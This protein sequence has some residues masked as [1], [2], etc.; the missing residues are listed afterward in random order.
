LLL[1]PQLCQAHFYSAKI[2]FITLK[3][4]INFSKCSVFASSALLHLFFTSISVVF[5]GQEAQKYFLLQG[6]GYPSYATGGNP[7][8]CLAQ[9]HSK[10]IKL[11]ALHSPHDPFITFGLDERFDLLL[12]WMS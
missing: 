1:S 2:R 5:C 9:G 8:K 7:I 11:P 4:T 12:V 6:V 10:P 3:K